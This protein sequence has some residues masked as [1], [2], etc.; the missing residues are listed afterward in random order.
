MAER[1]G[2]PWWTLG[3]CCGLAAVLAVVAAVG[4]GWLGFSRLKGYVEELEDP[5]LRAERVRELLGAEE[6]PPG[7]HAMF[8]LRVPLVAVIVALSDDPRAAES[9]DRVDELEDEPGLP[10]QHFF[11]YVRYRFDFDRSDGAGF[12]TIERV[13]GGSEIQLD[14][15]EGMELISDRQLG[16]GTLEIG[17]QTIRY[18]AH[19]GATLDDDGQREDGVFSLLEID[20]PKSRQQRFAVWFEHR[21]REPVIAAPEADGGPIVEAAADA[22]GDGEPEIAGSPADPEALADFMGH[23]DLCAP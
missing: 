8:F 9:Y 19:L 22:P 5:V 23:F 21:E 6:L 2:S 10:G 4:A 12:D 14:N 7:Y 18:Q 17:R 16:E 20:C 11:F 13:E 3:C 1:K 15:V